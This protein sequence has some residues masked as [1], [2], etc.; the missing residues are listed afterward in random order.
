MPP[1]CHPKDERAAH[2]R[3]RLRPESLLHALEAETQPNR[4]YAELIGIKDSVS[5]YKA[6]EEIH[7][8]A[9]RAEIEGDPEIT[10]L[11]DEVRA[12][13]FEFGWGGYCDPTGIEVTLQ[14][15]RNPEAEERLR[16]L[17]Q[18]SKA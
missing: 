1:S 17:V 16:K 13:G 5:E 15:R 3:G 2:L 8:P 4:P 11:L 14:I 7:G 9:F 10:A 12:L 6:M 18:E